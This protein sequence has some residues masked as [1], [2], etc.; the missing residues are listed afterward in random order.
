MLVA[1]ADS[2]YEEWGASAAAR[3]DPGIRGRGLSFS[4]PPTIGAMSSASDRLWGARD[5][6]ALAP[7]G[8]A[9]DWRIGW[10]LTPASRSVSIL[11]AA[12]PRTTLR[13]I[14]ARCCVRSSAGKC[15]ARRR[16]PGG[17]SPSGRLHSHCCNPGPRHLRQYGHCWQHSARQQML[18]ITLPIRSA[19]AST[20]RSATCA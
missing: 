20:S 12:S 14:T 15:R 1:H 17:F 7:D 18:S 10:R 5:A 6:R 16:R 4:L 19:A 11:S 9:R 13:P 8:G 3:L 2:G